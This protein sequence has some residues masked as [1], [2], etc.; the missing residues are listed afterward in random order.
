M[1]LTRLEIFEAV[2]T[3]YP[4]AATMPINIPRQEGLTGEAL[5][6]YEDNFIEIE[7]AKTYKATGE[8][9]IFLIKNPMTWKIKTNEKEIK[10]M[11]RPK[12]VFLMS[13]AEANKQAGGSRSKEK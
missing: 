10:T 7:K 1:K 9:G 5:T 8:A 13:W 4:S 12:P 2:A 3:D 11:V 6:Q